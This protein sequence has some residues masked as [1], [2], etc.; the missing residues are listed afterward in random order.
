MRI[1]AHQ[2]FWRYDSVEYGWIGDAM[3]SL[4]HDFLPEDLLPLLEKTSIDGTVAVQARQSLQE[5][6]WLIALA[7]A[8]D[9][10]KGVVGWV[11]LQSP[12]VS[13][14]LE[15][16]AQRAKFKG[17]RHVVQDEPDD[18]FMLRPDFL[19]GLGMLREFNLTYDILVFPKQ[20]PAAIQVVKRFP[21]Q[22]FVL[23]HIAKPLIKDRLLS[24]WERDI[25]RLAAFANVHCKLSGTVTETTWQQWQPADFRPYLDV[26][27]DCFGVDRLMFGSDWPVCT[28]SGSYEQVVSLVQNYIQQFSPE[29]QAKLFGE[30]AIRFYNL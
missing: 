23:D 20:L 16:Y 29:M 21:D 27:F 30:N 25:R 12:T 26:V 9:W 19:R 5:T 22:K 18:N 10:I 17:V 24:P 15:A 8:D 11:D 7:D 28:L 6:E 3:T 2:H 13:A 4:K 1:D 14:E